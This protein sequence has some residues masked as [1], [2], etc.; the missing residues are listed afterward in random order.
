MV[1][2]EQG[3]L[4]TFSFSFAVQVLMKA[5]QICCYS[6]PCPSV[7]GKELKDVSLGFIRKLF[8]NSLQT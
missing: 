1:E 5:E 3:V 7:L 6:R 4:K 8:E 2:N